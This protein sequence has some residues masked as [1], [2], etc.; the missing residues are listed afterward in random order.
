MPVDYKRADFLKDLFSEEKDIPRQMSTEQFDD[1][2]AQHK[3]L[4]KEREI[5]QERINKLKREEYEAAQL[6]KDKVQYSDQIAQEICE[7]ISAGELLINICNDYHMPTI[8][9]C[10]QWLKANNDFQALFTQAHQ[11]RLNIF[12]EEII[13][14]ADDTTKD[15]KE[16]TIKRVTKRVIDPEVI[17]RAKLRIEVRLRHLKSG[18]PNKWSETSTLNVN[19]KNDVE[20]PESLSTEEIERR[21]AEIENKEKIIKFTK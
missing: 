17:A 20:D 18:R 16:I 5:E 7:R 13:S 3:Q 2:V 1:L 14:I 15:Y 12:E 21:I 4:M 8:K 10:N 9:R 19:N 11:D 6:I